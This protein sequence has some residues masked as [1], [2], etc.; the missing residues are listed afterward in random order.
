VY[1]NEVRLGLGFMKERKGV[2]AVHET[3]NENAD[4]R[5]AI[6]S[7]TGIKICPIREGMRSLYT[8]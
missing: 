7:G 4:G 5:E 2:P 1:F 8:I 3:G 6:E